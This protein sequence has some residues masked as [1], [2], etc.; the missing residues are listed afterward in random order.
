MVPVSVNK[1]SI[2][3]GY[4]QAFFHFLTVGKSSLLFRQFLFMIV[5]RVFIFSINQSTPEKGTARIT[6]TVM[7]SGIAAKPPEIRNKR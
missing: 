5:F 7:K 6:R 1:K 3:L 2:H 4:L